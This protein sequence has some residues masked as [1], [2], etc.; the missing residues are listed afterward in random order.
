MDRVRIKKNYQYYPEIVSLLKEH[1]LTEDSIGTVVKW[2]NGESWIFSNPP[3]PPIKA[4]IKFDLLE[5]DLPISLLE[6]LD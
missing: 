5:I 6:V 2:V 3:P 1:N 4:T